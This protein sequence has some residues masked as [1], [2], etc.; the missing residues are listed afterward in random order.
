MSEGCRHGIDNGTTPSDGNVEAA[1]TRAHHKVLC[2]S[3]S[4]GVLTTGEES[5]WSPEVKSAT[6]CSSLMRSETRF[7]PLSIVCIIFRRNSG[8]FVVSASQS[9]LE[10]ERDRTN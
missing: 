5:D 9:Y 3:A 10:R 6:L 1:H 2:H 8:S 4:M 7:M